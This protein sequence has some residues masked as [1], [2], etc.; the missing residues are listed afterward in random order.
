MTL[1]VLNMSSF[2]SVQGPEIQQIYELKLADFSLFKIFSVLCM[3]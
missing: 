2:E 3:S 1:K